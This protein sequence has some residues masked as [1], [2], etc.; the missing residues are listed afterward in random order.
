M[1]TST[2]SGSEGALV[3]GN[4]D[5]PLE[6]KGS[7]TGSMVKSNEEKD[8][9]DNPL[10]PQIT[11]VEKQLE[12]DVESED[13][14]PMKSFRI[15]RP[16]YTQR[17]FQTVYK[18]SPNE[19]VP[20]SQRFKKKFKKCRCSGQCCGSCVTATLP[21]IKWL[22]K[23]SVT[24]QLVGDT[25]SGITVCA[26]NIPQGMAY[27]LLASVPAVYGLYLS[28]FA[29][30]VYAFTG[31]AKEIAVGTFAII[32]MMVSSAIERAVPEDPSD[33]GFSASDVTNG[34][35]TT[36]IPGTS[37]REEEL[38]VAAVSLAFLV[39]LIQLLMGIL[40]LGWVTIYLSDP[41]IRGYTTGAAIHVFTSQLDDLLGI[42]IPSYS[43][44]FKLIYEYRDIILNLKY[45]NYVT[46]LLSISCITVL[47]IIKMLESRF[48]KQL[49]GYPLGAELIVVI[50]G[51]L[52]SYLIGLEDYG[53]DI[54]GDIP[55]GLP[56][57]K[58]PTTTYMASLLTDALA[59]AIVIF[60]ISV[61][62]ASLFGQKNNYKVDAN[63]ELVAY[64]CTN[65]ITSFFSCYPSS[66]SM[67][68][69][70]VQENSGGTSQ[71][72][73]LV[74]SALMLV[75]LLFLAPL[76]EPLPKAVLA[77]VI[78]VALKGMFRQFSDLPKLWKY[79]II[80]FNVWWVT[81]LGV[82]LFDVDI[83]LLIGVS[84]SIFVVVWR[85]QEP[86][87]C[88]LGRIPGTDI[89]K[90]ITYV[91]SA[92]E[93][94]GI[95]IFR[96]MSSLYYANVDHFKKSLHKLTKVNPRK[97]LQARAERELQ[98]EMEEKKRRKEMKKQGIDESTNQEPE[99]SQASSSN[100]TASR[101]NSVKLRTPVALVVS[102]DW[103]H[104][105][106]Y[107]ETA[108]E[109]DDDN[110]EADQL[111]NHTRRTNSQSETETFGNHYNRDAYDSDDDEDDD[112]IG[113]K[114][115]EGELGGIHTIILDCGT[116]N[117]VD[118][119]GV[120]GL[121]QIFNAYRKVGVKILMA[122]AKRRVRDTISKSGF[123]SQV[124]LKGQ[125]CLFVTIHDAVL[126]AVQESDLNEV[127]VDVTDGRTRTHIHTV[128]EEQEQG[129]SADV[130]GI[131]SDKI[132]LDTAL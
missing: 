124:N 38:V 5:L 9:V 126:Y 100:T 56:A 84:F 45:A 130:S 30:I 111:S 123:Y 72:A 71:I 53:V 114:I 120:S 98:K 104:D 101:K 33:S 16:V 92:K 79:D 37:D 49:R 99:Q 11:D 90:D 60:A 36:G 95:K 4:L 20:Y 23:Y 63:Q 70:L 75:V 127:L 13:G 74:N 40:R 103:M 12:E 119:S 112:H 31:S 27:A 80:D 14:T 105:H 15:E 107:T 110:K 25:I 18:E 69:S 106:T 73:G 85:T 41:F 117:F 28:F 67:S 121:I 64:G 10:S 91:P 1:M 108:E 19:Y 88:L 68:R 131:Q 7:Q 43:G 128:V 58:P 86:Y 46:V 122:Q 59:I 113:Q 6:E 61:S 97:I 29:P 8:G 109:T 50:L 65:T 52:T 132:E 77:S 54:I 96:M 116:F 87:C 125:S 21:I 76:F 62:M 24:K 102:D 44:A 81:C 93:I 57:P 39:G 42:D 48:S 32:S 66:C 51:A 3:D 34:T 47:I 94:P 17:S 78:V 82:F 55:T 26:M 89:Y 35:N 115:E 22:P 2:D 118:S 129:A 83:G